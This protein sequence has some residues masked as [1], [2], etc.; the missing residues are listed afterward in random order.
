MLIQRF[1]R[2]GLMQQFCG[3]HL[4]LWMRV[5]QPHNRCF[6]NRRIADCT[7]QRRQEFENR[8]RI[9]LARQ[10]RGGRIHERTGRRQEDPTDAPPKAV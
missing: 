5:V 9:R 2:F 10:Q 8:Q 6:G 3:C 7:A 1:S 4:H